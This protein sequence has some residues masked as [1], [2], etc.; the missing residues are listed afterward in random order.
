MRLRRTPSFKGKTS[1]TERSRKKTVK[2]KKMKE[3]K[4]SPDAARQIGEG[5]PFQRIRR[6]T[7]YL[8]GTIDRWNDAKR[9]EESHRVKHLVSS[10]YC[11]DS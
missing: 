5:V 4:T 3:I 6:I 7:G 11:S 9:A 8:V 10:P 1:Q 2:E